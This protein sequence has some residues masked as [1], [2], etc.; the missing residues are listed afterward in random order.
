MY[1]TD[2]IEITVAEAN[3]S[4]VAKLLLWTGPLACLNSIY[5]W[6]QLFTVDTIWNIGETG[7]M[8]V[9]SN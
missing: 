3:A 1:V 5:N 4:V 6:T 9:K 8:Y 2:G 7:D